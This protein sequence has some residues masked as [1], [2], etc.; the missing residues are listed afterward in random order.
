MSNIE[1]E[2]RTL[3]TVTFFFAC[4]AGISAIATAVGPA[5]A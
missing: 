2:L 3:K 4:L 1:R 5:V